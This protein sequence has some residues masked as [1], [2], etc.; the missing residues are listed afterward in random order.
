MNK[1]TTQIFSFVVAI[2]LVLMLNIP[3]VIA[4]QNGAS[5]WQGDNGNIQLAKKK[6]KKLRRKKGKKKR[7]KKRKNRKSKKSATAL[8]FGVGVDNFTIDKVSITTDME[9]EPISSGFAFGAFMPMG[10]FHI[11]PFIAQYKGASYKIKGAE[12]NYWENA[13]TTV[14][15]VNIAKRFFMGKNFYIAPFSGVKYKDMKT[16]LDDGINPASGEWAMKAIVAPL[17][18]NIGTKFGGFATFLQ[19]SMDAMYIYKD[20]KVGDSAANKSDISSGVNYMLGIS[21]DL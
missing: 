16:T 10:S 12:E 13:S 7:S 1:I 17:G 3:Q 14:L 11:S 20:I 19:L 21:F 9:S 4:G 6:K 2:F 18:V 15:G 8:F 5:F